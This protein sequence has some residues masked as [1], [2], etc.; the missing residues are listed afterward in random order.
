MI[1]FEA[2]L[3]SLTSLHLIRVGDY[4]R[5]IESKQLCSL[6]RN[7]GDIRMKYLQSKIERGKC[8]KGVSGRQGKLRNSIEVTQF[9]GKCKPTVN[10]ADN[11]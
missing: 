9:Q 11:A 5:V 8:N 1:K 2:E 10:M 4:M 7:R 3:A 6:E